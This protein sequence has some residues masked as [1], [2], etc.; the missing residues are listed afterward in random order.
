MTNNFPECKV[1]HARTPDKLAVSIVA[2]GKINVNATHS[3]PYLKLHDLL[4]KT[5]S[6]PSPL[7]R[8]FALKFAHQEQG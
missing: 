6:L 1:R 7:S 8:P 5:L 2:N 4:G 3:I